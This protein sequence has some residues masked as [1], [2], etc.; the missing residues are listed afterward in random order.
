M[1]KPL[2]FTFIVQPHNYSVI[3]KASHT[4]LWP[5]TQP[6]RRPVFPEIS[7]SFWFP[8]TEC[9]LRSENDERSGVSTWNLPPCGSRPKVTLGGSGLPKVPL[10][11]ANWI[12]NHFFKH[13]ICRVWE[14]PQQLLD[15]A[16][17]CQCCHLS[18][19]RGRSPLNSTE[20]KFNL[21]AS[22][23]PD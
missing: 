3:L 16:L 23:T 2:K 21:A 19:R 10:K 12:L 17:H 13:D 14:R 7:K 6:P 11:R 22:S 20:S 8:S 4:Y 1:F 18:W 15:A 5:V 9:H